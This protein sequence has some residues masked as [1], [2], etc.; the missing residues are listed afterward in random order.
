MDVTENSWW[1]F[2]GKTKQQDYTPG[3]FGNAV[4]IIPGP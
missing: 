1:S 4:R 2:K 3:W